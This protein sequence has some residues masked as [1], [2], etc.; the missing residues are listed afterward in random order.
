MI[1]Y[2]FGENRF[3][4]SER[5]RELASAAAQRVDAEVA[6]AG[7][8][9]ELL[10]SASLFEP[11]RTIVLQ[12][13]SKN[14]ELWEKLPELLARVGDDTIILVDAKPDKRTKTFKWLQK[15]AE[16]VVCEP[17]LAKQAPEAEKWLRDYAQKSGVELA[18]AT[19][20]SMV[21]RATVADG[22]KQVIDQQRLAQAVS[23]LKL[24]EGKITEET[25]G[26][27]LGEVTTD[28]VFDLF[29][30]AL[31]G[32]AAR[33]QQ[34]CA[35]LA[36]SEDG[37]KVMGLLSSQLTNLVALVLAGNM[38]SDQVA[39]DIGAHPFAVKQLTH[40][41]KNIDEP[42]AAKLTAI[43]ATADLRIKKGQLMPWK[44]IELALLEVTTTIS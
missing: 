13:P 44:A 22:D 10:S 1:R 31:S 35:R 40:F 36:Q 11:Q 41:A 42:T 4:I 19:A 32:N 30:A 9:S 18:A 37:F 5:L 6:S 7:E 29:S 16:V 21:A 12:H 25:L 33:V 2:F 24:H 38:P 26:T 3:L 34:M 27:I 23:Q 8:I 43:F 28:A 17:L 15:N 20:K 39:K 14:A